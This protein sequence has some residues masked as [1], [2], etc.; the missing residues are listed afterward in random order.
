M[1]DFKIVLVSRPKT[2]TMPKGGSMKF[3]RLHVLASG[4]AAALLGYRILIID[5]KC[6]IRQF[7]VSFTPRLIESAQMGVSLTGE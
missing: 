5:N 4:G 6:S 7:Y 2:T 1:N 3:D